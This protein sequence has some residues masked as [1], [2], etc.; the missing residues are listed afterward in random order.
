MS[1][2]AASR[3]VVERRAQVDRELR[4][5]GDDVGRARPDLHAPDGRD[6]VGLGAGAA[7]DHQRH[8]GGG[9]EGVAA[10]RHRRR[11]GVARMPV[12]PDLEPRRAV[13]RGDDADRQAFGLQHR[14]LL[15]MDLDEGRDMVGAKRSAPSGSPPKAF[16]AS[17]IMTP[18]ASFWSSASSG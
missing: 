7:L 5:A 2:S 10:E 1:A 8:L 18:A 16:S 13:D 9:G 3:R 12:H 15:D 11:A 17:R 6:E 14:P 4:V